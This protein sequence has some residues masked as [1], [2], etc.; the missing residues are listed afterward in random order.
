MLIHNGFVC[1]TNP[2][3]FLVLKLGV[4]VQDPLFSQRTAV[5]GSFGLS[6]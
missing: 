5:L 3:N 4:S 2:N 1:E 6:A